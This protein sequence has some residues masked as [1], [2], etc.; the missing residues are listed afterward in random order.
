VAA[1]AVSPTVVAPAVGVA[2][3]RWV[4]NYVTNKN[5]NRTEEVDAVNEAEAIAK[6]RAHRPYA[7][8]KSVHVK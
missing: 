8:F 7:T 4:L 1:V 3:K 6:V 2:Q 5:V